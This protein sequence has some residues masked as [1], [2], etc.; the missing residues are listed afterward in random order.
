MPRLASLTNSGLTG[1]RL[2]FGPIVTPA[3]APSSI[4][5]QVGTANPVGGVTNVAIPAGGATDT[6][7]QVTG[8][9]ASTACNIKFT[10]VNG[11]S[12]TSTITI[13]GSAYTSGNNYTITAASS[14]SIVVVTS[15]TGR[16][17]VT[18]TFTIPV[19]VVVDP[20]AQWIVA[21][22][23][24]PITSAATFSVTSSTL[25]SS[26]STL[27]ASFAANS[28]HID[29]TV[30]PQNDF[31]Y[32]ANGTKNYIDIIPVNS[33]T[34]I[35]TGSGAITS[36]VNGSFPIRM[37]IT[38]DGKHA[39][40][41]QNNSGGL[42]IFSRN[43]IT[44]AL[45]YVSNITGTYGPQV[46][47]SDG[48]NLYISSG[49]GGMRSYS[50]NTT[51]GAL[52]LLVEDG[53]YLGAAFMTNSMIKITSNNT[54]VFATDFSS[55]NLYNYSRNM[56]TGALTLEQTVFFSGYYT[57]GVA[58][59]TD[60][61]F[62]YV[63]LFDPN[64]VNPPTVKM[65]SRSLSAPYTLTV[66]NT[67]ATTGNPGDQTAGFVLTKKQDLLVLAGTGTTIYSWTRNLTTGV[68]TAN[69][70]VTTGFGAGIAGNN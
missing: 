9:V 6:T 50:R 65:L 52:T 7:G 66:S 26:P 67:Y 22:K 3:T 46:L 39:Y 59:S 5:L 4:T 1:A 25:S 15:E 14:L 54:S 64:S 20:N 19:A 70:N 44:G 37:S 11:G 47:S 2:S 48:L 60:G 24:Y 51:T 45:T 8:W 63:A 16:S 12:A 13:N 21:A 53:T 69:A 28:Y 23:G 27:Y 62:V 41:H 58:V 61:K 10:V 49:S 35:Y 57:N 30:S 55:G 17:D 38:P 34:G 29:A 42:G 18:R 43:P 33:N 36:A 32:F 40:V 56:G 68:L 31:V